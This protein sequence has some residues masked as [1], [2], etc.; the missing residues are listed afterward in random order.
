MELE[1]NNSARSRYDQ[2]LLWLL[3]YASSYAFFHIFPVLLNY[4]I[5]N[6]LM[7]ADVFDILTPFVMVLLI[8]KIYGILLSGTKG[9]S[10]TQSAVIVILILGAITFVEG[11]GM[12]LSA[13]AISRHLTQIKDSPLFALGYF[14]DETLGHI[15]WDGGI[16]L[17]SIGLIVIAFN[18]DPGGTSNPQLPLIIFASL[19]YGFTYFCNGVEGQTVIFTFPL[20][21]IIPSVIWWFGHRR[22]IQFLRNPVLSFYFFAYL[23]ALCLFIFWGI[24]HKGFPEFS[25]LGWI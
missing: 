5:K 14:F 18:N 4:E 25:A 12:H 16:I 1:N 19:L 20:A 3:I 10:K 7:M 15:L 21:L 23:L 2:L 6:R 22:R 24:W 9:N 17:L 11:H 8:Y 13:N